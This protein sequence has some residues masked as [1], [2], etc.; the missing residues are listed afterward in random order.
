MP[1]LRVRTAARRAPTSPAGAAKNTSY[2]V[3]LDALARTASQRQAIKRAELQPFKLP[4]FP[5]GAAPPKGSQL[6]MDETPLSSVTSWA[7]QQAI[8]S[9]WSE[10]LQF[11]GYTYLSELSQRPEYRV[12]SEV[13]AEEMTRKWI[14]FQGKGDDDKTDKIS[15]LIDYL[16]DMKLQTIFHHIA[17]T[18]GLMGRAHIYINTGDGESEDEL[19]TPL[20]NGR[21]KVSRSKVKKGKLRGFK[22]VEPIWAYP[23]TY[24]SSDPLAD[25]WYRPDRWF[26]MSRAIHRS[27]LLSFVGRPV[28]DILKPAYAFGGLSLS[29]MAKPYVD[30]WL[31]TRQ[32][33]SDLVHSFTVFKLGTD[34]SALLMDGGDQLFR[35]M[36]LFNNLRDNNNLF[37]YNEDTENFDNTSAPLGTLDALLNKSQE[38]MAAVSRIPLVKLL[39]IQPGGLNASSEGEIVTFYDTIAAAQERLFRPHLTTCIDFAQISLWGEVDPDI[40]FVFEPLRA[41]SRKEEAEVRKTDAETGQILVTGGAISQEE[42]RIRIASDPDTPYQG[43]DPNDVPDLQEEEEAGL[44]IPGAGGAEKA[45]LEGPGGEGGGDKPKALADKSKGEPDKPKDAGAKPKAENDKGAAKDGVVPFDGAGDGAQIA[46]DPPVSEPQRKA[47]FAAAEGKSTLGIPQKVG[48]EFVGK[49]HDDGL[50]FDPSFDAEWSEADHDRRDDGK[51]GSGSEGAR[52]APAKKASGGAIANV[53]SFLKSANLR[54]TVRSVAGTLKANQ[55][56]ILAAAVVAAIT[57]IAGGYISPELE[58]TISDNVR[59]FAENAKVTIGE[60]RKTMQAIASKLIAARSSTAKDS[61]EP[62]DVLAAIVRFHE[63]FGAADEGEFKEGDHPRAPDGKFGSG[64]SKGEKSGKSKKDET[65]GEFFSK[66]WHKAGSVG[67][68]SQPSKGQ[69]ERYTKAW[70]DHAKGIAPEVALKPEPALKE[71]DLKRVGKQMGSNPGGVFEDKS[72]QRFYVKQGKSKAHVDT[73]LAAADLYKLAGTPTLDYQAVEGGKHIATKMEKLDADRLAK[74]SPAERKKAQAD[75]MTHAW[76]ANWDAVGLGG[77]NIGTVN[78]VPTALDLGGALSYRAMGSPKGDKFGNTVGEID[79]LRSASMNPDA[80]SL[81]GG[82]SDA[83]MKQSAQ[84][85]LAIPDSAIRKTIEQRSLDSGLADKLIAR[86]KDIVKRF[87]LTASDSI[88]E[89]DPDVF[90]LEGEK[91][92]AKFED[93]EDEPA[94]DSDFKESDHPRQKDGKFGS[95]GGGGSGGGNEAE[96]ARQVEEHA[97]PESLLQSLFSIGSK[98][99]ELREGARRLK[100]SGIKNMT[101][102]EAAHVV[103]YVGKRYKKLNKQLR[104]GSLSASQA[105]YAKTLNEALDKLPT[106]KGQTLRGVNLS[107]AQRSAYKVGQV[108]EDRGFVSTGKDFVFDTNTTFYIQGKS[109]RDITKLTSDTR[110]TQW[111]EVLFKSGTRFRVDHNDGANIVLSEVEASAA[112][113]A[114]MDEFE[115]SKHPRTP[116]G[117]FGSGGG[118]S[119]GKSESGG[120]ATKEKP[121]L[122][123]GVKSKKEHVGNLLKKGVTGKEVLEATGWPSVSMPQLAKSLG[124]TLIKKKEGGVTKYYSEEPGAS[125]ILPDPKTFEPPAPKPAPAP[126]PPAPPAPAP[127]KPVEKPT[128]VLQKIGAMFSPAKPTF[129]TPSLEDAQKAKKGT[130]IIPSNVPGAQAL[131]SKFNDKWAAKDLTDPGEIAEKVHD[132]KQ[133]KAEI[134]KLSALSQAEKQKLQKQEAEKAAAAAKEEQKKTQA[135]LAGMMLEL[136]IEDLDDAKGVE[137]IANMTGQSVNQLT[138]SMKSWESAAKSAGVPELSAFEYAALQ[139]YIGSGYTMINPA[140]RAPSWTQ[141]THAAAKLLNTALQKMPKYEGGG[142]LN[143]YSS[144]PANLQAG[145]IPGHIIEERAFTSSSTKHVFSDRNTKFTITKTKT[146]RD[147]RKMNS[148]EG[149]IL[150][151]AKTMFKVTKN[152]KDNGKTHIHMEEVW[153]L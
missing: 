148:H 85:V 73:E 12:I 118:S 95:G 102:V 144:L 76:L 41:L 88:V 146:A 129:P 70:E 47:M 26:C 49:P 19:Q 92:T 110:D 28:P 1:R 61:A 20:G 86:K 64:G 51:F 32:S 126:P 99:W 53:R 27:R 45:I 40:V 141:E 42:E 4:E 15:E 38:Q 113:D 142:E 109:G 79:T 152:F 93:W 29:Q 136:G 68:H 5:P 9:A 123:E 149:E 114:A 78:G 111:G 101:P 134:A 151:P 72:G 17:L 90:T 81:Y 106:Y 11:L 121:K 48:E 63:G 84:K 83:D 112:K 37:L 100:A 119:S 116:D 80:A 21:D 96:I 140:L 128:S 2:Q 120:T 57:K 147:I 8:S 71:S 87:G 145:Y 131:E 124:V 117:K 107:E 82:M 150:F 46:T 105:E 133:V 59:N 94:Q 137:G 103:G 135:H 104:T 127:P 55:R 16:D 108:I 153:K 13:I 22:V 125:P 91:G 97:K 98:S 35:R 60:A 75:F 33:V 3:G 18:D 122:P 65:G 39:G 43:L 14:R 25:N 23:L 66:N 10:G 132:Y 36:E 54:A 44:A 139:S 34:L 50:P 130:K 7:A 69:I 138:Q 31:R 67:G 89:T 143:R 6:A 30:N 62:D 74:L 77:D 52:A 56:A 58:D 24:N 115:E